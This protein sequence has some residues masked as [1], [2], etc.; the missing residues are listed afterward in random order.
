MYNGKEDFPE[1]KYLKFSDIYEEI[2]EAEILDDEY[3]EKLELIV[4]IYNI[5]RGFNPKLK[6]K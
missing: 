1:K 5:N 3:P 2:G 6:R 4:T